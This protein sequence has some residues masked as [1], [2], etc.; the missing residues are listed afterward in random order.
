MTLDILTPEKK[1]FSG[2]AKSVLLPGVDGV[3]QILDKHAPIIAA[4]GSGDLQYKTASDSV[5]YK[6][7]GGFVECLN[8]RVIVLA[9]KAEKA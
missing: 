4:L 9:E 6:V 2:E 7:S 3:F 5:T 1:I 8:N